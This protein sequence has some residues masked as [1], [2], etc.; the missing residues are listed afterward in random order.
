MGKNFEN[1]K[2]LGFLSFSVSIWDIVTWNTVINSSKKPTGQHIFSLL[3][4]FNVEIYNIQW[5]FGKKLHKTFGNS[6][7]LRFLSF[8]VSI[9][10]I[11]I[12][13][14]ATISSL[15]TT[16]QRIVSLLTL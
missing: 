12:Q 3:T 7:I 11:F 6:K 5:N 8:L 2:I 1:W 9:W 13:N 10:D 14:T 16:G 4:F 15:K